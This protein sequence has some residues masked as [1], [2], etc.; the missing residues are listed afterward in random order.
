MLN[1][2]YIK[3]LEKGFSIISLLSK[4]GAPLKLEELVKLS[5]VK[6]TSCFRI[7]QTLTRAGFAA[8]DMDTSGY[9]IGPQMIS[10]GLAALGNRGVREL[11]LP[12]M[13]EISQKTGETVNLAILSGSD[14]I[15]VERLQSAHIIETTLHVG[16]RL[17]AH[18]SSMGKAILAHLPE[19][20]LNL[21]LKQLRFKKKTETSIATVAALKK[22]LK[23][24][25]ELGFAVNDEE[26]EQ[27]LFAIAAPLI[28]HT[29]TAVAA[30]NI[31]FPLMRH[32]REEAMR[33]F[34]PMIIN[35]GREIS[36]LMGCRF[37]GAP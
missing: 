34:R 2:D 26:L 33:I 1:K 17:S 3:S 28:D 18:L 30:I 6:K 32:S 15:F 7:L 21:V 13:K 29:G 8:R 24:V 16:Y 35:A 25:R 11:A 10:I 9:F 31:S 19:A 22:E 5:G 27:G 37:D 4:H 12:F 23:K 14:V 20:E 36:A